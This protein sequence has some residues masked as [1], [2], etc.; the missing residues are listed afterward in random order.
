MAVYVCWA[1]PRL[2]FVCVVCSWDVWNRGVRFGSDECQI[3]PQIWQIWDLFKLHFSTFCSP[4]Q[5][6]LN[7]DL[8]KSRICPFWVSLTH[9]GPKSGH[10]GLESCKLNNKAIWMMLREITA[11]WTYSFLRKS[12]EQLFWLKRICKGR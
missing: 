4:S 7:Y 10:P 8:K 5:N 6:V 11:F 2:G 3:G 9:F 12:V 1:G